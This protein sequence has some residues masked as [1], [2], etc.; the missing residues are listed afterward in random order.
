MPQSRQENTR[1][2]TDIQK[3]RL[4]KKKTSL[5]KRF[6]N[7]YQFFDGDI[8][9]VSSCGKVL[10][11]MTACIAGKNLMKLHYQKKMNFKAM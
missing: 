4:Q 7:P 5:T 2:H 10:I 8:E 11:Q 3:S 9:S 6:L 1:K